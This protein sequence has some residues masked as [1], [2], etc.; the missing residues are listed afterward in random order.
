MTETE[1]E[2]LQ[3]ASLKLRLI[4]F[5]SR[6]L[7]VAPERVRLETSIE[8]DLGATGEDAAEFM[9][10]YATEFDV[11]LAGFEFDRHF[12]GEGA[13]NPIG[14]LVALLIWPWT[15]GRE[16]RPRVDRVTVAR[17]LNGALTGHW[18]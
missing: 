6:E 15:R 2:R 1:V 7:G 5:V 10:L 8:D 3:R 11:D 18:Q 12:D 4:A 9:D 14:W 17:L 16:S 13:G